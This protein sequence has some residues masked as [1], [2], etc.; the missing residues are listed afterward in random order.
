MIVKIN[1]SLL[2]KYKFIF[3][4]LKTIYNWDINEQDLNVASKLYYETFKLIDTKMEFKIS[5][6]IVF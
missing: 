1:V 5:Q 2:N 3:N 4:T 6:S